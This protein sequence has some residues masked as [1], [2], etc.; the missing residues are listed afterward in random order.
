MMDE[1]KVPIMVLEYISFVWVSSFLVAKMSLLLYIKMT[2]LYKI[3]LT[4]QTFL[5][6]IMSQ[7]YS[8]KLDLQPGDPYPH[9]SSPSRC[10]T[11]W[12][13]TRC[14]FSLRCWAGPLWVAP[15]PVGRGGR[16]PAESDSELTV[17]LWS[18]CHFPLRPA[19]GWASRVAWRCPG[20]AGTR[21]SAL[22]LLSHHFCQLGHS[23]SRLPTVLGQTGSPPGRR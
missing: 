11:C 10:R 18:G 17:T 19:V 3:F 4:S 12:T 20:G 15:P 9:L 23:V 14:L 1:P 6:G 13:P 5:Y 7:N 22:R 16:R 8:P 21:S 2:H